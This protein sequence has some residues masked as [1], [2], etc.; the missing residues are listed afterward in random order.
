MIMTSAAPG[1]QF[2]ARQILD[3]SR[4]Y[5]AM[6]PGACYE[7]AAIL[8]AIW[9]RLRY[10]EGTRVMEILDPRGVID[11]SAV[12]H[13]WNET[14]DGTVIDS[15][16]VPDEDVR[17]LAGQVRTGRERRRRSGPAP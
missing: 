4:A 13:G 5:P 12:E 14:L 17:R 3:Q 9:P 15:A 2:S 16:F 6:V 11:S 7:S 1:R 8:S 10:A